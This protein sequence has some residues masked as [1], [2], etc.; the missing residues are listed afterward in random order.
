VEEATVS[1]AANEIGLSILDAARALTPQI[2]ACADEIERERRL[3]AA[4]FDAMAAAGLFKM[5]VPRELGGGEVDP[6]TGVR[7]IEE[8]ARADGSAAWCT[9]VS[10]AVGM[11][12]GSLPEDAAWTIFGRDPHA[13]V[14]GSGAGGGRAVIV[15][16]G[17]RVSGR[18]G[19]ASGCLHATWLIGSCAIFDGEEP[20]LGAD[21]NLEIRWLLFP[22]ADCQIL[23]T[24]HVTG[25]RGS[26]SDDFTVTD[27]FVPHEC[28]LP[29]STLRPPRQ[30]GALYSFG[31][32]AV[33]SV[34]HASTR[35]APW[36]GVTPIAFAAIALGIA[37][38]ALDAFADL[39]GSKA[40]RGGKALLRDDVVVQSQ[41]GQA[42]ATLRAARAFV[43]ETTRETW[44][45]VCRTSLIT[46]AQLDLLRLAGTHA[47]VCAA[48]V[49]ETVWKAAGA[50]SIFAS[51]PLERRF[52]DA[53]VITQNIS[54][55]P[56]HYR[57]IA[58]RFLG[59]D[60]PS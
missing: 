24:W 49:V 56:L 35:T 37:R 3:P 36:T 50:S 5:F 57:A 11:T 12:A 40:P 20:H 22:V 19:F 39:A 33:P 46:T 30:P 27:V 23:D 28:S 53:H 55:S 29:A 6:E 41:F 51:N 34:S 4:L 44:G 8:I 1:I 21:G 25:L 38:G 10:A 45:S 43:Y 14:V 16:G 58:Q 60:P 48:Q 7:V 17:Y 9:M 15:E 31:A 18:W 26:G 59:A 52:R 54:V 47:A 32:G 42:E 2:R 13:F